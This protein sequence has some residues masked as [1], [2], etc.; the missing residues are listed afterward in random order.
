MEASRS[1]AGSQSAGWRVD[2]ALPS[3]MG[4]DV[5]EIVAA[6]LAIDSFVAAFLRSVVVFVFFGRKRPGGTGGRL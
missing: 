5:R 4:L 3:L 6:A 2:A 1:T